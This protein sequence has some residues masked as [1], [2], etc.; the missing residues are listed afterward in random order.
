MCA[1]DGRNILS[2]LHINRIYNMYKNVY[3]YIVY[4]QYIFIGVGV[5]VLPAETLKVFCSVRRICVRY[6]V[7]SINVNIIFI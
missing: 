4:G 2:D 6:M 1:H 7:A 3:M 5:V